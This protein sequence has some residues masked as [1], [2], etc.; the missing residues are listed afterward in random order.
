[1]DG[2]AR[3]SCRVDNKR[4]R[5][6]LSRS[7]SEVPSVQTAPPIIAQT[8]IK[9]CHI[10]TIN[11]TTVPFASTFGQATILSPRPMGV[12]LEAPIE[13]RHVVKIL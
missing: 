11:T 3:P 10:G 1:M 8:S 9:K 4:A 13:P 6:R 12:F 7:Q 2:A 5:F